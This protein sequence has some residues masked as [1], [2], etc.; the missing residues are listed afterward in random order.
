[1]MSK[2]SEQIISQNQ[3]TG[4]RS[5]QDKIIFKAGTWNYLIRVEGHVISR[6][7]VCG[8][9][10]GV[11]GGG[12][13]INFNEWQCPYFRRFLCPYFAFLILIA[14]FLDFMAIFTRIIPC[15]NHNHP[16]WY[17]SIWYRKA[18]KIFGDQC[19]HFLAILCSLE[20]RLRADSV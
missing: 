16:I 5:D 8:H 12:E 10:F 17:F 3:N 13:S 11:G 20:C 18:M 6:R 1:M 19:S 2:R 9:G 7:R 15:P 4:S 14:I